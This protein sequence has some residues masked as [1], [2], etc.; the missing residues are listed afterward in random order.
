MA[1]SIIDTIRNLDT[2]RLNRPDGDGHEAP[3]GKCPFGLF[4]NVEGGIFALAEALLA[5]PP[6]RQAVTWC[7]CC[8]FGTC[9]DSVG[10]DA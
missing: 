10:G 9:M 2:H 5:E 3:S 7:R 8:G 6:P 4:D 1:L